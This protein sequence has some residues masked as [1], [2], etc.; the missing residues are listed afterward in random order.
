MSWEIETGATKSFAPR[1]T[2]IEADADL[3]MIKAS[4][5]AIVTKQ[6][7]QDRHQMRPHCFRA[8]SASRAFRASTINS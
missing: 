4:S 1:A 5:D 3:N 2:L 7:D 8:M 6:I